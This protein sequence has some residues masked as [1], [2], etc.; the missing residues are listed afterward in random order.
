MPA[1]KEEL[2][3]AHSGIEARLDDHDRRLEDGKK[4]MEDLTKA[5]DEIR[6]LLLARPTWLVCAVIAG[7]FSLCTLLATVL[8]TQRGG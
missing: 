6:T 1:A 4:V 8:F 7:L 5:V 2:C 3:P